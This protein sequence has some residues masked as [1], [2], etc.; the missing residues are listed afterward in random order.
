MEVKKLR[1]LKR[2]ICFKKGFK[3]SLSVE[4]VEKSLT[5]EELLELKES[6]VLSEGA[7]RYMVARRLIEMKDNKW[8]AVHTF[9]PTSTLFLLFAAWGRMREKGLKK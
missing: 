5:A 9:L 6:L 2:K 4:E 3:Y 7:K 1:N 8:R